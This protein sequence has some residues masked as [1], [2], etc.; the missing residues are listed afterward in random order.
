MS[1]GDGRGGGR[2]RALLPLAVC[3]LPALVLL[4]VIVINWIA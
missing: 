1:G 3:S 4:S 2:V